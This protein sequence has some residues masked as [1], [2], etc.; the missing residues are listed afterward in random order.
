MSK[1]PHEIIAL[2]MRIIK[3]TPAPCLDHTAEKHH[4]ASGGFGAVRIEMLKHIADDR[5]WERGSAD[6]RTDGSACSACLR[7]HFPEARLAWR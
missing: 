1:K 5:K 7:A 4:S 3:M 6:T 2:V